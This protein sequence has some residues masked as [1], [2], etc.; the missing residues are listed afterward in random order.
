MSADVSRYELGRIESEL[1][2]ELHGEIRILRS[3]VSDLRWALFKHQL[4][5]MVAWTVAA[6]SLL[7]GG[8]LW[9]LLST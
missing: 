1:R 6:G 2:S 8:V 7:Y 9:L 4:N 3:E 5:M